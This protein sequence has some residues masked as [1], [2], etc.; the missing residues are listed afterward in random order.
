VASGLTG[1]QRRDRRLKGGGWKLLALLGL[2]A[3]A[4]A[5]A[6]TYCRRSR[7]SS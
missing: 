2:P 4:Y 1:E 6:T 7:R 3:F 5:L